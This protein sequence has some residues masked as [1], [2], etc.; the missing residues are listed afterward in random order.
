MHSIL[1]E[2]LGFC[3][4]EDY[5]DEHNDSRLWLHRR[6]DCRAGNRD[7][8][9]ILPGGLRRREVGRYE[10]ASLALSFYE[11]VIN[12]KA[13]VAAL[14]LFDLRRISTEKFALGSLRSDDWQLSR[15]TVPPVLSVLS[16][17]P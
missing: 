3:P 15:P 9:R 17:L 12:V 6:L 7:A 14:L 5:S 10:F 8:E 11:K 1:H 13:D 2:S 16:V 4:A